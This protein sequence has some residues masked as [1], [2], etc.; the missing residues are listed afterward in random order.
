[1]RR[2]ENSVKNLP[3]QTI[4]AK[5][6]YSPKLLLVAPKSNTFEGNPSKR[7]FF[8]NGLCWPTNLK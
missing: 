7:E 1:M 8:I 5:M 2:L 6:Q 3:F 4:E